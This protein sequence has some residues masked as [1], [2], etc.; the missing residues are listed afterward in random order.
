MEYTI[1]HEFMKEYNIGPEYN[2]AVKWYLLDNPEDLIF[3]D[4]LTIFQKTEDYLPKDFYIAKDYLFEG[5]NTS[6][7]EY[8]KNWKYHP[9][10]YIPQSSETSDS[11][12]EGESIYYIEIDDFKKVFNNIYN[13]IIKPDFIWGMITGYIIEKIF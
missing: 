13:T 6:L 5:V 11:S 9:F 4:Y 12:S 10:E 7:K 8:K 2:I 1:R 3:E